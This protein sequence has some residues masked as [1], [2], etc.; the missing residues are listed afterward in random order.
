MNNRHMPAWYQRVVEGYNHCNALSSCNPQVNQ[1]DGCN[2]G[3]ELDPN[4][5]V[6]YE[7][8]SYDGMRIPVMI[9]QKDKYQ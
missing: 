3:L 2:R 7:K 6:H 5:G 9:C 4:S 1:C 8:D